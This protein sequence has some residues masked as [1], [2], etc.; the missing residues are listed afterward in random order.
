MY[1]GLKWGEIY[2]HRVFMNSLDDREH[3]LRGLLPLDSF[4]FEHLAVGDIWIGA[5]E[6]KEIRE[7]GIIIERKSAADLEASILDGRYR[8]QRSRLLSYATE[9]KAHPMYIIEGDLHS[10]YHIRLKQPALMKHLTR[11]ALR[12]HITVFQTASIRET[13][14]LCLLLAEQWKSD[15]T[16]FAQPKTM[17]YIETRGKT[18]QENSDDPKVFAASVLMCCRGISA[19]G[20]QAVLA[21]LGGNLAGVWAS[22]QEQMAAVQIGKQKLG[23]VKAE[24]LYSLLH[25]L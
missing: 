3:G 12:Y 14:E 13:A 4:P 17:T 8:E 11:L 2:L 1:Y 7:H 16:T 24:R 18:R 9:K 10:P 25:N 22:S 21:A 15:P 6:N 5:D 19:T 23:N 20:A